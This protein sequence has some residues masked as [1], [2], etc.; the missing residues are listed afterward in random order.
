MD[1]RAELLHN[2]SSP[3]KSVVKYSGLAD[4][5]E[6]ATASG[7]FDEW[8]SGLGVFGTPVFFVLPIDF[9]RRTA[10]GVLRELKVKPSI[11]PDR[12]L[13]DLING[14]ASDLP[15]PE[16]C[17]VIPFAQNHRLIWTDTLSVLAVLTKCS[18]SVWLRAKSPALQAA[19][20]HRQATLLI[21]PQFAANL[22]E[23]T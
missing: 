8:T 7:L 9:R 11:N 2:M 22:P 23:V 20:V 15:L 13:D 3:P 14:R 1:D 4:I 18:E 16:G 10:A 17:V 5:S 19:L 12:Q 6:S 21:P